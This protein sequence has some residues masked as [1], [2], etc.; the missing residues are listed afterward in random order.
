MHRTRSKIFATI[1][2]LALVAAFVVPAAH[3]GAADGDC[4]P[5]LSGHWPGS[6]HSDVFNVDTT[7]DG[8]IDIA[9]GVVS[10]P[11]VVSGDTFGTFTG[12]VDCAQ[13]DGTFDGDARG[14]ISFTATYSADGKV[15]T[16]TYDFPAIDDHGT[17]SIDVDSAPNEVAIGNVDAFEGG[18]S[19]GA[20]ALSANTKVVKPSTRTVSVPVTLTEPS[21][22]KLTIHYRLL[23][24]A[25]VDFVDDGKTHTLT[26]APHQTG[27]SIDV[28]LISNAIKQ[29]DRVI[30]VELLDISNGYREYRKFGTLLDLDDDA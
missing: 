29:P 26:I 3:V 20:A 14:P 15:L 18:A 6:A 4:P 2:T 24:N 9:D 5:L 22:H 10:G 25:G 8:Q 28:K 12:T 11:F 1:G 30:R 19:T 23:G 17:W 21:A 7:V 16:G 27:K 13:V